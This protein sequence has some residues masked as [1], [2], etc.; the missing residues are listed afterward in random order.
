MIKLKDIL[1][2]V[3]D[4]NLLENND[5]YR[6]FCDLDGVL[7][8]FDK[9][10]KQ[11]TGGISFED[12]V[13]TK[14]YDSLWSIINQNGSIWWSTLPWIADGHKLWSF[15]KNK[16]VTILTAG[17]TK[18]TGKLAI[19]G[20]KDWCLK[21]LSAIVPVIVTNNSHDKQQHAQPN[22]IL[23]DDL[24]S[25]INEWKAKGGI[26]ILHTTAEQTINELQQILR[27]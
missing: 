23:I 6:I 25:N 17:S 24:P 20:K 9:G 18:N 12:Y 16:D 8:D 11:L 5:D 14:G 21:N 1:N 15:I 19:E 22:H 3:F 26:G 13:K 2:E 7:V 27:Q 4:T 10:V